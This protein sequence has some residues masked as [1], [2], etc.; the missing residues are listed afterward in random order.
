[1][2]DGVVATVASLIGM[3]PEGLYLLTSMALA[4]G[5]VRLAQKKTLVHDMGCIETLARVDVLCVDKTGTVTENKMAVEDVVPLCPDRFEE[6]DIRLIM[7]DYV[8]RH[9]RGQRHH[10][11]PAQI[12]HRRGDAAGR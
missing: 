3:I 5:V 9:A 4:A 6:E 7:A 1:M 8:G 11:R 12:L 10:G 2:S